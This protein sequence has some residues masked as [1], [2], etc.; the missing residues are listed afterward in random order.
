MMIQAIEMA[1]NRV[2]KDWGTG[3]SRLNQ[4]QTY[5]STK[6]K[7]IIPRERDMFK[8]TTQQ[9]HSCDDGGC[10]ECDE[11]HSPDVGLS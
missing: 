1:W 6:S 7:V 9:S 10:S 5:K 11:A 3:I 2:S 8:A 4:S